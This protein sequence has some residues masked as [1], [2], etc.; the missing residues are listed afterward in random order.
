[1]NSQIRLL[2]IV[3]YEGMK[4]LLLRLAAEYPQV[5]LDV[6]VGN[7]EEGV[8]IAQS[9]LGNRYDAVISRGGTALALRELPLPVVEI[10]AL[11]VRHLICTQALRRAPQQAGHGGLCQRH[12]QRPGAL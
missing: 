5:D 1:M 4:T 7:M 2:G 9:N 11:P 6:F 8:K 12:R 10:E 3:P